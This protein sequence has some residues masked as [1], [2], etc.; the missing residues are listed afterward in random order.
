[1]LPI[2]EGGFQTSLLGKFQPM[3]SFSR[4]QVSADV[5]QRI[6]MG[7]SIRWEISAGGMQEQPDALPIPVIL[8]PDNVTMLALALEEKL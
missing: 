4:W 3:A 6:A 2:M 5:F 1:M 8:S 7:D